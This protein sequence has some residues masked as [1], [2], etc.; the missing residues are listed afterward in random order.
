MDSLQEQY[1]N[2]KRRIFRLISREFIVDEDIKNLSSMNF[3]DIIELNRT[4]DFKSKVLY[5]IYFNPYLLCNDKLIEYSNKK[6]RI[7]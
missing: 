7:Y 3:D 5:D 2:I 6:I 4:G 1:E